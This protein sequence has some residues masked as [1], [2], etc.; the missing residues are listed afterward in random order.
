MTSAKTNKPAFLRSGSAALLARVSRRGRPKALAA[1]AALLVALPAMAIDGTTL[2]DQNKAY[3]GCVTPGD[4]PGFPI[5]I[6]RPGS[7]RL[8]S[9]LTVPD[10]DTTAIEVAADHVTID[11]NGFA[12]LG[13]VDCIATLPACAGTGSG[14]GVVTVPL[15]QQASRRANISIRNGT[16]QGMGAHGVQLFGDAIVID[17]VSARGNGLSGIDLAPGARAGAS[18]VRHS[19]AHY[20]ALNGISV[21]TGAI[22]G[23]STLRN[24]NHG[25]VLSFGFASFNLSVA[26]HGTGFVFGTGGYQ[27]NTSIGQSPHIS[28]NGVN[29]GQNVCENVACPGAQF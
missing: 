13:P 18:I 4:A 10:A 17:N 21:R 29:Q 8:T 14:S 5:T 28:G 22:T 9:N 2:I 16:I 11:L 7:Y 1:A 3:A 26:N 20:N 24:G 6:S 12:I 19:M 25:M 27:G 23:S 15:G